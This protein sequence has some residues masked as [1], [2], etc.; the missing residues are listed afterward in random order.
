MPLLK[1]FRSKRVGRFYT[2]YT[3][4]YFVI[5]LCFMYCGFLTIKLPESHYVE[6]SL[7][8]PHALVNHSPL[9]TV[10]ILFRWTERDVQ[11]GQRL[12]PCLHHFTSSP[13]VAQS[14]IDSMLMAVESN[15]SGKRISSISLSWWYTSWRLGSRQDYSHGLF[16]STVDFCSFR[17]T[18]LFLFL[19]TLRIYA[20]WSLYL[21]LIHVF[22]ALQF[23]SYL[24]SFWSLGL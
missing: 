23:I 5:T 20:L 6:A 10:W 8:Y 7:F 15:F 21:L 3:A 17:I 22:L 24:F 18:Y 14:L 2:P 9:G 16:F 11:V 12:Y 19:R 4:F 1:I 13:L